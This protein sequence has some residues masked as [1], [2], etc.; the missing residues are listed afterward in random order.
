MGYELDIP[1]SVTPK[2]DTWGLK[3]LGNPT[4]VYGPTAFISARLCWD[5]RLIVDR[6]MKRLPKHDLI[7][8]CS[9]QAIH[10]IRGGED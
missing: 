3:E 9:N 1:S 6:S 8:M 7:F 5:E 4:E 10:S 2:R